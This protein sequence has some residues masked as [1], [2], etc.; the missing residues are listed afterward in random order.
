SKFDFTLGYRFST[1][2]AYWI[3]YYM[4]KA[5]ANQG[6]S[7]RIPYHLLTVAHKIRRK[8]QEYEY[9]NYR[10]PSLTELAKLVGLEEEKILSVIRI[11]Q[12]PISIHAK[13]GDDDEEDTMEYFLSDRKALTPEETAI[14]RL[15]NEAVNKAIED[16]PERLKYLVKHFYGFSDDEL[17]L[18]EIGRRLNIS[19][20]RARQLL[21]QALQLLQENEFIK[22]LE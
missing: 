22:N 2:A 9:S 17:N 6:S 13:V 1:Y 14:E 20:E 8:I 15:K 10:A 11:T 7:I 4:Q 5:V 16:L 12:T 18:A 3:R 19:R 21:H